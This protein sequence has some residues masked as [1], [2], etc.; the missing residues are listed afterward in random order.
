MISFVVVLG[1]ATL[2]AGTIGPASSVRAGITERSPVPG[3]INSLAINS[4]DVTSLQ[5]DASNH[6]VPRKAVRTPAQRKLD[7]ALLDEIGIV[8]NQATEP[9]NPRQTVVKVDDKQR[10]M[11]DI[12]TRVTDDM[13]KQI[14]TLGGTIVSSSERYDSIVAWVPLLMLERLAADVTV[15]SIVPASAAAL[16]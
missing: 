16:Q 4:L 15:R 10:A 11:V 7:A 9:A 8:R 3:R 2:I 6:Q 12:R 5:R 1:S 13:R 14:D